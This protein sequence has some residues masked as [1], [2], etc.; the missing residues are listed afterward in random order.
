MCRNGCQVDSSLQNRQSVLA[1][2]FQDRFYLVNCPGL[3][4]FLR[5]PF[6]TQGQHS[7]LQMSLMSVGDI[8]K[9]HYIPHL[10]LL[11]FKLLLLQ[12][13]RQEGY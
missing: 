5:Q 4:P 12:H 6:L 8:H 13:F 7:I 1:C 9:T 2:S 10:L 11:P 3:L